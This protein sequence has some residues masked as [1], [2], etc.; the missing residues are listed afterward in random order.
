LHL[1]KIFRD[2][3][4]A[5]SETLKTFLGFIVEEKLQG[6]E[7]CLKEYTIAVKVLKKGITFKPQENC[8]VR[9]HAVRLRKALASYYAGS[10]AMDEIRIS[11]PKGSYVPQFSDNVD[12]MLSSVFHK[13]TDD[14][15][16][17]VNGRP[18]T[19][20]VIPFHHMERNQLVKSFLTDWVFS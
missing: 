20:A 8:I 18:F 15:R 14:N 17:F 2:E 13:R 6:R 19:A 5:S 4:F 16:S 9:I 7:N 10:G 3:H 11:L 1:D 12:M